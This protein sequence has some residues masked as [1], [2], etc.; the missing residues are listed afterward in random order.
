[1]ATIEQRMQYSA[2]QKERYH[3]DPEY[4][5]KCLDYQREYN[6][7][8]R[9]S[10]EKKPPRERVVKVECSSF[11]EYQREYRKVKADK[12]REYRQRYHQANREKRCEYSRKY[13]AEHC[14][15]EGVRHKM[16]EEEKRERRKEYIQKQKERYHTDPEFREKRREYNRRYRERVRKDP[17]RFARYQEWHRNYWR[18]YKLKKNTSCQD[19]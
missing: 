13:Y 5:Q 9:S 11:A 15:R 6:A 2:R 16:T 7:K 3:N 1:M 19:N 17:E 10:Q 4:R 8:K 18:N 14:K 12:M